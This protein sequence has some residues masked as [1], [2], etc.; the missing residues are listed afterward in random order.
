MHH[1]IEEQ[2]VSELQEIKET[3]IGNPKFDSN[4]DS[5]KSSSIVPMVTSTYLTEHVQGQESCE[6]KLIVHIKISAELEV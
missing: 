6:S 4:M 5:I 2:E 3:G 1:S